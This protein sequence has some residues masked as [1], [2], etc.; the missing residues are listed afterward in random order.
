MITNQNL[1]N[2]EG[3]DQSPQDR[4]IVIPTDWEPPKFNKL[5]TLTQQGVIMGVQYYAIGTK[6]AYSYKPGW[7]Y[8]ISTG[9]LSDETDLLEESEINL[10]HPT[11]LR[12]ELEAE[13]EFHERKIAS[14]KEQLQQI[15]IV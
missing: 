1:P 14:L 4:V 13:I 5:G 8:H 15:E 7:R 3:N 9:P 12:E 11:E 10:L 2:N 6:L